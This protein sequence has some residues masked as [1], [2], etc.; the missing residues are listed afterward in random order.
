MSSG[1]NYFTSPGVVARLDDRGRLDHTFSGDG[2]RV[3]KLRET[4][5]EFQPG[6]GAVD[7]ADGLVFFSLDGDKAHLGRLTRRGALDARF[8]RRAG[9]VG[10]DLDQLTTWQG[11]VLITDSRYRVRAL[12]TDGSPWREFATSTVKVARRLEVNPGGVFAVRADDSARHLSIT[13]YTI[14]EPSARSGS[15]TSR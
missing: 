1:R 10:P 13:R 2:F 6:R 15:P 3:L 4:H 14:P 9:R 7:E 11:H 8:A 5:G 12:N